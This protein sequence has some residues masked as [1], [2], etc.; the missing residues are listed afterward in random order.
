MERVS[1]NILADIGE[2]TS[3]LKIVYNNE[4]VMSHICD[5]LASLRKKQKLNEVE[6]KEIEP[7]IMKKIELRDHLVKGKYQI[8]MLMNTK[9]VIGPIKA[10]IAWLIAE[11]PIT[12]EMTFA[13]VLDFIDLMKIDVIA[14]NDKIKEEIKKISAEESKYHVLLK[15]RENFTE[16]ISMLEEELEESISSSLS[17]KRSIQTVDALQ[18]IAIS[19]GEYI[20]EETSRKIL[21]SSGEL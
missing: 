2:V 9:A 14:K 21:L 15:R 18:K 19:L 10:S 3:H 5:H 6:I 20:K 17:I 7:D 4:H 13:Q 16:K 8:D 11:Y 12:A 1:E